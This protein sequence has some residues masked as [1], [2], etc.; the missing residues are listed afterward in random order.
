MKPSLFYDPPAAKPIEEEKEVHSMPQSNFARSNFV[1]I[2]G[3]DEVEEAL[4]RKIKSVK[5]NI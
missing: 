3:D 1:V 5:A 4:L 2:Q